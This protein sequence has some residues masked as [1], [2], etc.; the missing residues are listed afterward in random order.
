MSEQ[1]VVGVDFGT[2]SGRALVV[3]VQDGR[4]LASAVHEYAHAVVVD[5]LPT[6]PEA[7]LPPDWA[8]QV[9][10]D[11]IDV[12]RTA[13][14]EAVR[15]SGVDPAQVIGIATDF[16]ACTMVPTLAD[17]TPLNELPQFA[18][19]PHAYVKLWRHHAA[20]PQ[21]D[22]INALAE[23]RDEP[24]LPRYGGLISSEWEFAKGLQVLEEDPEIYHAMERWVEAADWITWRLGGTY[25]RNACSAG[26]KG[27]LQDGSYP[28]EDFL[29][30]L[31]P[32]FADFVSTKLD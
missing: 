1:Y 13:V 29:A 4:E 14:P 18:D 23:Q 10:S 2:L 31:N 19:R 8:L 24:W 28:E 3:G 9:P 22:R 5:A 32:A 12:L 15:L 25:L 26:Y 16:T 21:A 6:T 20:Q 30:A 27:I 11:Y 17:G 7:P